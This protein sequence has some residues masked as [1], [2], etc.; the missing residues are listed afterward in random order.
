MADRD[1]TQ[2]TL[3]FSIGRPVRGTFALVTR[4]DGNT[5]L[6]TTDAEWDDWV[7]AGA[8]RSWARN[9]AL[10]D[11]LDRY[12]G[13][14][15]IAR[16]DQRAAYDERFDFQQFL[17]RQGRRFE[18]QVLDDLE[19]RVGLTRIDID[20]DD[21]RSLSAAHATVAA[22]ERGERVIAQ[23]LLR[24]PQARTYGRIDLLMRS[25][26]LAMLCGDAFAE[27]DDPSAAAPALHGAAWHYRVID[28]KFSTL[29]LLKDGSLSTSS[30]LATCAQVWTYNQM[31]GRVQGQ[32]AP[33]G[34]VLGRA[35]RQG[36]RGRGDTC[37]EKL[38]RVPAEAYVRSR[39]AALSEVVTE[40]RDWIRRVRR[41]GAA[42]SV[43]P[44]PTI[45]EL[46]PNMKNDRDH[47]WHVAK[48]EIA[49][50]LRELTL[51]WRVSAAM[52]DRAHAHGVTRWDDERISADLLGISGETHPAMFD[53]LIA[54]NRET[55]PAVRPARIEADDGRWREQ[56]PL[57]VY[58]DFET[59]NDLNDDFGTFP[60]KGGQSLIF[61]VG[62]GTYAGGVWRFAQFTARS[63]TASAEAD[64]IDAWLAHLAALA[65]DAGLGGA[66]EARIFHWSPAETTFM[67][68]A[69]SS[70]M[71]RHPDRGWPLLGWYDLLERI[72][73]PAPVVVRGARSFGLKAVARAMRAHGLIETEWGE[74]LADGTGAMAGAWAAA[75]IAAAD[76]RDLAAVEL[77]RDV[78]RYNEIDCRVMAEVL[79]HLRRE[80]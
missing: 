2:L 5:V 32:V 14:R 50:E 49:E 79:Q 74:G 77:M 44:V 34:Y 4:D 9:D 80:H 42:W 55:G 13:E 75:D 65:K 59:V 26:V 18:E 63:L 66:G 58:V 57:E 43:L 41:D 22:M 39:E 35:W 16:D 64:M 6:P 46:W 71:A 17:A 36:N 20:R 68:G 1:P 70:A 24:D 54:A 28:I 78:S 47:P 8:V 73:H 19:Q 62:C 23:G 12:G 61:Q 30:D 76:G 48:R 51:L 15:G 3:S 7:A 21:A 60:R 69:Y 45:A 29:E 56:A 40:G 38:A 27:G 31:L 37:W 25:D 52:R 11:W 10:L 33:F 53:A 72:V 67:E